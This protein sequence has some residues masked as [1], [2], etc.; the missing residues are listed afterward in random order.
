MPIKHRREFDDDVI[1]LRKHF[2]LQKGYIGRA[3]F[4]RYNLVASIVST[5]WIDED[6]LKTKVGLK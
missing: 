5:G 2:F 3:I 6:Q 1:C 4:Q